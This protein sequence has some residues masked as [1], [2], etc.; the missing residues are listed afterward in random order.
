MSA[1]PF[2]L[3]TPSGKI[4]YQSAQ[5]ARAFEY[6]RSDRFASEKRSNLSSQYLSYEENEVL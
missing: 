4:T 2:R 1:V 6:A 3:S 5:K